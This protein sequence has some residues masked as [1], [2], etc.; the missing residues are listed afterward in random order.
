MMLNL[1]KSVLALAAIT[2]FF[3]IITSAH[4]QLTNPSFE[5]GDLKG[6][7]S[8]GS[9][10]VVRFGGGNY[11]KDGKYFAFLTASVYGSTISQTFTAN[12]GD[13]IS[14]WAFFN[15]QSGSAQVQITESRSKG[16]FKTSITSPK[17]TSW[18][19]RFK[20][21]GK[22]TIKALLLLKK[23]V[24]VKKGS[25]MGLDGLVLD[26][27]NR[28]PTADAGPDQKVECVGPAG[29]K[30]TLDGSGSRDPDKN[31]LR[32]TWNGSFGTVT[33]ASPTVVLSHDIH[34]ITLTV[35]DGKGGKDSDKVVITIV[36]TKPP[37]VTAA[38]DPIQGED[39]DGDE[40]DK[41]DYAVV[42]SATD[43]C[44][45]NLSLEAVIELPDLANPKVKFKVKDRNKIK[46]DLKKNKVTLEG[47]DPEGLWVQIQ[48]AGG[49]EV[50][51]GQELSIKVK[52]GYNKY[53]YKFDKDGNLVKVKAPEATLL[54]TATDASGNVGTA[55]ASLP[56]VVAE[57]DDGDDDDIPGKGKGKPSLLPEGYALQQNHPNP[58]NPE[59]M[60]TYSLPEE[61][62]IRLV[63]YNQ[64]GQIVRTLVDGHRSAGSYS[65]VWDGRDSNGESLASGI[66]LY[67][68]EADGFVQTRK[69]SLMR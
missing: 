43:A 19:Y 49:I 55:T 14:G 18:E 44:D 51:N 25:G 21:K 16:V 60:I 48:S 53:E 66:Y 24:K 40:D 5:T 52:T 27:R 63:V 45:P 64:M 65:I 56:L 17:W 34:T 61:T 26:S 35:D 3:G 31:Y 20:K 67:R 8:S 9:V 2:F 69:M 13:K 12:A 41:N 10:T 38:L 37:E 15:A 42:Y 57:G 29:T 23:G 33:G 11:P 1:R 50:A 68:I 39:D 22:Y 46:I 7:H 30:V 58:F 32:Y 62:H 28:P 59:T 54:C 4:A 36:D 47:P 6:W